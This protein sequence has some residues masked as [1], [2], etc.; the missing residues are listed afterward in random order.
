MVGGI[1]SAGAVPGTGFGAVAG[2]AEG[3]R[4]GGGA[5]GAVSGGVAGLIAGSVAATSTNSDFNNTVGGGFGG[6]GGFGGVVG[7][8]LT[9][10]NSL[11]ENGRSFRQ[12]RNVLRGG[13]VGVAGGFAQDFTEKILNDLQDCDNNEECIN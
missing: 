10:N 9:N 8:I 7:G 2:A 6:F 13:F 12:L 4:G 11:T 3:Y 1:G 5:R